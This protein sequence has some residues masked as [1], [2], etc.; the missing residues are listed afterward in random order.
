MLSLEF[1][2]DL[3][4]RHLLTKPN[5]KKAF[6]AIVTPNPWRGTYAAAAMDLQS[7]FP[8]AKS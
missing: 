6:G 1:E 3:L 8:W 4:F 2:I 7:I 5:A